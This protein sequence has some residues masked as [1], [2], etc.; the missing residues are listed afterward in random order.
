MVIYISKCAIL[1][2]PVPGI[3]LPTLPSSTSPLHTRRQ[4]EADTIRKG[5][6]PSDKSFQVVE[7]GHS[8]ETTQ[9][10]TDNHYNP[11]VGT[12]HPGKFH[13]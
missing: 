5:Q 3:P 10:M 6:D 8:V 2:E 4:L 13:F 12:V 9:Q 11:S 7:M 1:G